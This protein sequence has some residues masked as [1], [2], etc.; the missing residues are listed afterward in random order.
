MNAR[1]GIGLLAVLFFSTG[2]EDFLR[3]F[4]GQP[5]GE[6]EYCTT[7]WDPVCGVDGVTYPNACD[8]RISGVRV[9][10]EGECDCG[11]RGV[12]CEV[13]CVCPDV[14]EPVCDA[15]GHVYGNRCR[16]HCVGVTDVHPCDRED[17]EEPSRPDDCGCPLIWAPVCD[18]RGNVYPNRC[19]AACEGVE[20]IGPCDDDDT[21]R[22]PSRGGR[23]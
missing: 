18:A 8:A 23:R 5:I 19:A 14:W 4:L 9:A 15:R 11:R 12:G 3:W 2:C 16:A 17:D 6:E 13:D 22:D 20:D 1:I 7:E 21:G 10:H